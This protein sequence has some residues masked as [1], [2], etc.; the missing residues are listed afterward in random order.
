MQHGHRAIELSNEIHVVFDHQHGVVARQAA[1]QGTGAL[2]LL[3]G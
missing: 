1:Q 2:G 3:L